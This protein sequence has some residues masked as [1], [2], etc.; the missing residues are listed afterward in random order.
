MRELIL[1]SAIVVASTM[2]FLVYKMYRNNVYYN[3]EFQRMDNQMKE[4]TT[5]MIQMNKVNSEINNNKETGIYSNLKSE[6]ENYSK[7]FQNE[8]QFTEENEAG[9]EELPT[10]L[11]KEI[12]N[13]DTPQESVS[14]NLQKE[15]VIENPLNTEV[16]ENVNITLENNVGETEDILGDDI[17]EQITDYLNTQ[18]TQN[19]QHAEASLEPIET[20]FTNVSEVEEM[21]ID[22]E[23]ISNIDSIV[24][25]SLV[26]NSLV[27]TSFEASII[28]Q[29]PIEGEISLDNNVLET[30][31][32]TPQNSNNEPITEQDKIKINTYNNYSLESL[33]K[34]SIKE[35]QNIA[36][37]NKLK[38]KGRKD[39]LLERVK[40]LYNLNQ[41]L[42]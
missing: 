34:L 24:D 6:Y 14:E 7:T 9:M 8:Y 20:N 28:I 18:H 31:I 23:P 1:I 33:E 36:R 4:L 38:I 15:I 5:S 19:P 17:K 16:A 21:I 12:D 25:N 13:I 41:N 39:E 42:Y 3:N 2:L 22:A 27:D 26:D 30:S 10:E 35:L 32:E 29:T 37:N 11:K 40:T